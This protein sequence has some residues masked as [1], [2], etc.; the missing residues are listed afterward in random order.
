MEDDKVFENLYGLLFQQGV[1]PSDV[2]IN[3]ENE[4]TK[5][6]IVIAMPSTKTGIA[7]EGD[8]P[9]PLIEEGWKIIQLSLAALK[10]SMMIF[11]QIQS[12][13]VEHVVN[14]SSEEMI[15]TGSK[16]EN[17]LFKAI[18]AMGIKKPNRNLSFK[19]EDGKELTVPDFAWEDIKLAFFVDGLW[20]HV[21]KDDAHMIKKIAKIADDKKKAAALQNATAARAQRDADN[22]SELQM[23]G[24]MVLSC[25]D[26]DLSTQ[27]GITKQA[28]R[29]AKAHQNLKKR[30]KI[31]KE[32]N[33]VIDLL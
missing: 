5:G 6:R 29:I 21:N 25:T 33:N 16:E 26:K 23:R 13:A 28:E 4:D 2:E 31:S 30:N 9:Q 14:Q 1:N 20:W 12:I 27:E 32:K 19:R 11:S 10:N 17:A 7:I 3:Y 18:I 8:T 22:R 24:W 15:K